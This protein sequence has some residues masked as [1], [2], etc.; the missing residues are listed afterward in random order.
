MNRATTSLILGIVGL[1]CCPI[2]GPFAL[3]IGKKELDAIKAGTG[4][5]TD[6]GMATAGMVLGILGTVYLVIVVLWIVFFG[7]LAFI[8]AMTDMQ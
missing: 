4:L 8:G 3:F 2:A 6:R 7:G 1:V 5:E